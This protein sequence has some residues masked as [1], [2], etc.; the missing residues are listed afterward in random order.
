MS[1]LY[2]FYRT[3]G[4]RTRRKLVFFP[5]MSG[6]IGRG[7]GGAERNRTADPLLAKQVL[8]QLSY[9]PITLSSLQD[10]GASKTGGP[11]KTRTSDLTLIKR[12]L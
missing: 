6:A 9:S 1:S 4:A 7:V 2:D 10:T 3:G 8:Y 11:G 12:A 5:R